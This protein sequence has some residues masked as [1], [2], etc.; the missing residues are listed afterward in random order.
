M[1]DPLV[2]RGI[3]KSFHCI[4]CLSDVHAATNPWHLHFLVPCV[5]AWGFWNLNLREI[6]SGMTGRAGR[7]RR[8]R[9][10]SPTYGK[11]QV[12]LGGQDRTKDSYNWMIVC[13]ELGRITAAQ[14]HC[15][16]R[17]MIGRMGLGFG[18]GMWMDGVLLHGVVFDRCLLG[19]NCG[20]QGSVNG[21]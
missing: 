21:L 18:G 19:L 15:L 11:G 13:H 12:W 20:F 4:G 2:L 14:L 3:S 8:C 6:G 7:I 16:G 17:K 10:M 5:R 9:W 1:L